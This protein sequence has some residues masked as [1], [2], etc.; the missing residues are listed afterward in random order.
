VDIPE[1][2]KSGLEIIPVSRMDE[3]LARALVREPEPISWEERRER[4]T[5]APAIEDKAASALI[6][7]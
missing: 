4:Q 6:A 5:D 2:V 7:H 1:S 3:V